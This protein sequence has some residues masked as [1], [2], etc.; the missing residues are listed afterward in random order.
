MRDTL[1]GLLMFLILSASQ[2]VIAQEDGEV[3]LECERDGGDFVFVK[4]TLN[5]RGNREAIEVYE[6]GIIDPW[7]SRTSSLY[8]NFLIIPEI[9]G[10]NREVS[11]YINRT[12]LE[13]GYN[14]HADFECSIMSFEEIS[15]RAERYSA[16][17][18][19]RRAF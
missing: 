1:M 3:G 4:L 7:R 5:E 13:G 10:L 11:F 12:T 6:G 9:H 15:Q 19:R 17:I 14:Y 8:E 2:V 16:R 18:N